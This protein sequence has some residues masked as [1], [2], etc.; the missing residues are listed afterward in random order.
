MN[1]NLSDIKHCLSSGE[2]EDTG[3]SAMR[4]KMLHSHNNSYCLAAVGQALSS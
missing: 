1:P 2:E 4:N 3:I